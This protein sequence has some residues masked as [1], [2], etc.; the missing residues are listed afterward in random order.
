MQTQGY[1]SISCFSLDYTSVVSEVGG[2]GIIYGG[3][4]RHEPAGG[5][6]GS[7]TLQVCCSLIY[8]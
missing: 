3:A 4:T 5:D 1:T 6:T 8:A 7:G 2:G